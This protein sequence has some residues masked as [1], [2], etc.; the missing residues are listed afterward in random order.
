MC[1][2]Y[3]KLN[4]A[5]RKDKFPLPFIN[6]VLERLAKFSYF[7][8]LDRLSGFYQIPIHL[9]DRAKTTYTCPY[10]TFTFRRM[11]FGFC[12]APATF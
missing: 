7:Y 3:R 9:E 5:T 6:Q 4:K 8:Y 1:I 2:D 11:P 12:N 10:N